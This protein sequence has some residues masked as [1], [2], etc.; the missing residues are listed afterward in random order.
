MSI[1]FAVASFAYADEMYC[2]EL[3]LARRENK[4]KKVHV[5][6]MRCLYAWNCATRTRY[7]A[8]LR[9]GSAFG[10]SSA[11]KS[12]AKHARVLPASM[13]DL[14]TAGCPSKSAGDDAAARAAARHREVATPATTNIALKHAASTTVGVASHTH[15]RAHARTYIRPVCIWLAT[16]ADHRAPKP[17]KEG[18]KFM[19]TSKPNHQIKTKWACALGQSKEGDLYLRKMSLGLRLAC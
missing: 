17:K 4:T 2:K 1:V 6:V 16:A 18:T 13:D 7:G 10:S 11:E 12:L 19:N 8:I 14:K 3:N 15:A 9:R 5:R